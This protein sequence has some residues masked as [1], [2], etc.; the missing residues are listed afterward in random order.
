MDYGETR[1]PIRPANMAAV[2]AIEQALDH[3]TQGE[4]ASTTGPWPPPSSAP[5][6]PSAVEKLGTEL[7]LRW[8]QIDAKVTI[9]MHLVSVLCA[10]FNVDQEEVEQAKASWR[11][12]APGDA[13]T[14]A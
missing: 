9:L 6:P 12:V 10:R 3:R 4:P 14:K 11:Q 7:G 1:P 13:A 2:E 8:Q 5:G